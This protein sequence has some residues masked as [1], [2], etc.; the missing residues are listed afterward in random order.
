MEKPKPEYVPVVVRLLREE[1]DAVETHVAEL[2]ASLQEIG[3][4]VSCT[5]C[6]W[7][8]P[9][10]PPDGKCPQCHCEKLRTFVPHSWTMETYI[11]DAVRDAASLPCAVFPEVPQH[12]GVWAWL[13]HWL[14]LRRTWP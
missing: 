11:R 14:R 13:I 8:A 12:G 4:D 7:S 6:S 1:H 5:A 3:G 9:G 2:N 10:P